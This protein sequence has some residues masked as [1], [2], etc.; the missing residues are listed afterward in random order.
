MTLPPPED[1]PSLADDAVPVGARTLCH[2]CH[3]RR[4]LTRLMMARISGQPAIV[5]S[6]RPCPRCSTGLLSGVIAPV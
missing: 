5:Y 4:H 3:G 6:S 2:E 1:G